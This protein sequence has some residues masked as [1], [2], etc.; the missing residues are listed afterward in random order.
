MMMMMI[1][2]IEYCNSALTKLSASTHYHF[3]PAA[4]NAAAK[5]VLMTAQIST[6]A[7]LTTHPLPVGFTLFATHYLLYVSATVW[8]LIRDMTICMHELV[9]LCFC[10]AKQTDYSALT[11]TLSQRFYNKKNFGKVR[12]R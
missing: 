8:R 3:S 4:Q 11:E 1:S 9:L 7:D 2:G 5:L 10:N 12:N 6:R